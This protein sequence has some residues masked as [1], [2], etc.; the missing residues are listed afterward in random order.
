LAHAAK[1]LLLQD[2]SV[3]YGATPAVRDV[4]LSVEPGEFVA[5]LGPSG[6]GKSTLLRAISGLEPLRGG[7]IR[8][9]DRDL[10]PLR[11]S[12]RG[13]AFVFQSYA[14]YPQLTCR[15]N[16]AAPL[17]MTELST[18]GRW[19]VLHRLS[20]RA[21]CRRSDIAR[22]VS[23]IAAVLDI[24]GL[25]DR[26]P[27]ALSGG[28]QQ[29]VALARALVREPDLF[30]LDEPLAN[31]DAALRTRT[32]SE[33][34]ALQQRIGATTLFVTHDQSEAMAIS[35][36]I[37]VMF[38]GRIRQVGTPDELYRKPASLDVA[39]FLSQPHLNVLDA[40]TVRAAIGTGHAHAP[41]SVAG[42]PL[43]AID[44]VLAFRPEHAGI[45]RRDTPGLPGLRVTVE[46]GEHGGGEAVLFTRLDGDGR[47]LVVRLPSRDLPHWPQ[48]CPAVVHFERDAVLVFEGASAD[49]AS[50][51]AAA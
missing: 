45:R 35:D 12:Q 42:R 49:G 27:H 28:Q 41:I 48:G 39:Q 7:A 20:S 24:D 44:G 11:P 6:C 13:V 18:F 47:R 15:Q 38:D 40:A 2:V 19:P 1:P 37:A 3:A 17:W 22:R 14:L 4:S 16:I 31:L 43:E 9:G 8:L 32:R 26:R 50:Q 21:V 10:A 30:L 5:I 23:A 36:R 51:K 46:R 33:L 25:L 29:R 34:R